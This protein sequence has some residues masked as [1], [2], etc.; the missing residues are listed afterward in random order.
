[1]ALTFYAGS[2]IMRAAGCIVNDMWDKNFDKMVERT[3]T[4]PLAA[5]QLTMKQAFG[6]LGLHLAGGLCVLTQLNWNSI[7]YAFGIIPLTVL[8]PVVKRFS[9]YPQVVLGKHFVLDSE[10]NTSPPPPS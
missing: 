9:H 7:S 8:Y 3:K 1:M 4:R 2:V 6:F 10:M 5:E